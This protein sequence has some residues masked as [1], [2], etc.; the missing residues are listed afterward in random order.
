MYIRFREPE[1]ACPVI[2]L[3]SRQGK[4][5]AARQSTAHATFAGVVAVIHYP[6]G[7]AVAQRRL[8]RV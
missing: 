2:T 7:A 1:P 8:G 5:A 3:R 4:S 6:A